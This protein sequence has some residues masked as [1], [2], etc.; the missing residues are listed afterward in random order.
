MEMTSRER[1][2]CVLNREQPD[3]LPFNFWMDRDVMTA[4]DEK[5]GADF[6]LTHYGV[7]VIEAFV[8]L[9]FW[10]SIPMK[11]FSDGKTDWQ[12]E[13]MVESME[14][15]LELPM[16][17]PADP[18]VYADIQSKRAANPDKAIFALM[19]TPLG[20]LEPLRMPENLYTD[21]YDHPEAI[22]NILDRVRPIL[23][24]A[25]RKACEL[26]IDVLYPAS[27]I[28]GR[29]GA[30]ISPKQLREF[31]FD[32]LKEAVDVTHAAGKKVFYHS[33]GYIIPV[34]DLYVEY[35]IDGCNPLEPRYNETQKFAELFGKDLM[36]YG[37]GDNCNIIPNGTPDEV[38]KHVRNQFETLNGKAPFIFSTHDIPGHCPQANLDA[39]VEAIMDCT[40]S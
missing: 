18:A 11:T 34:L 19:P 38:R 29:D 17:D 22:H 37:G 16:P 14:D 28:C 3:R 33:D 4:Y 13:P 26:D 2:Q 36:L 15:A 27:D 9:P 40:Y 8:M 20:C 25:A 24:E 32:Y 39:M 30:L 23:V 10:A 12:L 1:V 31:H 7:D 5:W 21:L 35:G 6:R